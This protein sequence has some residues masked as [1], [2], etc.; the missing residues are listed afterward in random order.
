MGYIG[1]TSPCATCGRL[2]FS[3][4]PNKVPSIRMKH[5]KADPE[6]DREPICDLCMAVLNQRRIAAGMPPIIVA[7][8]A[9]EPC[10]ES[11]VDLGD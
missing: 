1:L 7:P 3:Y 9:Y 10:E 6:G 4:N 11:E 2:I 8:D 5:G